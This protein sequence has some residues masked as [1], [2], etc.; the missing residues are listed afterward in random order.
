M[1]NR[2]ALTSL[3]AVLGASFA[4]AD[5]FHNFEN[6]SEGFLGTSYSA[7]GVTYRD[8]NNVSGFFPPSDGQPGDPFTQQDLGDQVIIERAVPLYTDMPDFG[9]PNNAM[10]FGNTY[11][12]GDN[13]SIGVL[14]S[15]FIDLAWVGNSVSFN[16]A[17]YENGH[18]GNIE[19]RL[20][21]IRNGSVVGTDSFLIANGGG[22][23]NPT[24]KTMSINGVEF[25]TL[26]LY[27]KL[28]G[29]YTAPR[30]IIDNVSIT[31]A[32]VPEPA[33]LAALGLGAMALLR[34]RKK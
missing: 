9:T 21:A 23:D 32:P 18:W 25:D 3:F 4:Q 15:V 26:Q 17:Y 33:T 10:T 6:L 11:I 29:S 16:L 2:L 22:R 8:V 14:A 1:T 7:D 30:G 12:N 31:A 27:A 5:I 19:Y 20:D 28:D 34:K 13:L 24:F